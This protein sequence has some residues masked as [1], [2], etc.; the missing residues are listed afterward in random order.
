MSAPCW[1][2][3]HTIAGKEFGFD[4]GETMIVVRA[5]HGLKSSGASFRTVLANTLW[6]FG[7][8]PTLADPDVWIKA[9]RKAN[10]FRHC[11][12]V[13][14]CTD[15]VIS[16]SEV[17]V[18][19]I[20]GIKTVFKLKGDKAEKPEVCLGGSIATATTD[21]GTSCWTLSSEKC[22]NSAVANVEEN[23]AKSNLRLPSDCKTPLKAGYNPSEDTSEEL[24]AEGL[25][26]YQELIEILR[27]AVELG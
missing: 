23:L 17:P 1:E 11:E 19:A 15:D 12:M 24:N 20:D 27:W 8:R 10:G 14:T 18:R 3:I 26:H 21:Q 9:A 16:I 22:V 2:K 5:L 6:E 4:A 13:L 7:H 25:R